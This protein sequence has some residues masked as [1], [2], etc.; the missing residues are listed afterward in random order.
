MD[1]RLFY[2]EATVRCASPARLVVL[3]Y[4]QALEDLRRAL[5]ALH[6]GD[7]EAR[8]GAINHAILVIGYLQGS[9][10]MERGGQVSQNLARFY[11][12]I[13]DG[14]VEAQRLQSARVID[15]QIAHLALVHEAWV[16]VERETSEQTSAPSPAPAAEAAPSLSSSAAVAATT[17]WSA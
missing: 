11:N 8:T 14:L 15:E 7:V 5:A 1:A 17:E 13:R 4:E 10:D 3:L 12:M 6:A 16:E 2:R 9:L